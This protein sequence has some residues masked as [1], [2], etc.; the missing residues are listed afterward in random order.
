M[1]ASSETS[2]KDVL[3]FC[4]MI[5]LLQGQF[6]ENSSE[7]S[8]EVVRDAESDLIPQMQRCQALYRLLGQPHCT[9]PCDEK[10]ET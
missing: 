4:R 5:S 8:Y 9:A 1:R 10:A 6:L 7:A 3:E 2:L